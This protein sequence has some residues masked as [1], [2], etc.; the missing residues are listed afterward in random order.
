MWHT[1]LGKVED[2]IISLFDWTFLPVVVKSAYQQQPL[3]SPQLVV[4]AGT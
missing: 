3:F 4:A 1:H 2:I